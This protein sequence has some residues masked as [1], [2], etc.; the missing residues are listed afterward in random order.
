MRAGALALGFLAILAQPALAE[1]ITLTETGSTLIYPLFNVW[2]SEYAKTHPGVTIKTGATGSGAGIEQATSGAVQIGVSDSYMSDAD[3]KRHP[4]LINVPMAIS[5]QTVNYNLPGLNDKNLKLDGPTLADIYTGRIRSWDDRAIAALNPGVTLP[6]QDIVPVRRA[7]AAGDTFIFTQYLT[8]STESWENSPGFG[9]TIAWPAVPGEA[10]A[11]G[12]DGMVAKIAQTPYAIGYVGV[13]YHP[14]IAKAGLGTAALK[15]YSGEFLLPTAETI[16]AAAASLSPRTPPDERLTLVNAPG[17]N[18][19]PLIN[20]EYAVVSTKQPNPATADAIRKFLLWA[21]APD[22][23]NAKFLE[24]THFI[25]LPAHIW[26]KSYDQ[27][28]TIGSE[29]KA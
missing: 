2:A 7:E 1:P 10:E 23:T 19:Y 8:F 14:E 3:A 15:S 6:H 28:M 16:T 24:D 18:C 4:D 11:T 9:V 27:I 26:V 13:S 29:N 20:Y 25:P 5:A 17:A 12:N 22:E 21:I